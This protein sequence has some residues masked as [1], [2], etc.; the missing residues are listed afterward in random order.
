MYLYDKLLI[1]HIGNKKP[2]FK[3]NVLIKLI[4]ILLIKLRCYKGF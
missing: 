1:E 4:D 2:L 3:D